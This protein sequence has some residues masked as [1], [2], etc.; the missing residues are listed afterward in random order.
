M[1]VGKPQGFLL[2]AFQPWEWQ[3]EE[4]G[5]STRLVS[6]SQ[7]YSKRVKTRIGD[8]SHLSV[9]RQP[10]WT[11][12]GPQALKWTQQW[13]WEPMPPAFPLGDLRRPAPCSQP[14]FPPL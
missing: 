12:Q 8:P 3:G 4:G 11:G 1:G 5:I 2:S 13:T 9:L 10:S 6:L 7:F 14:H